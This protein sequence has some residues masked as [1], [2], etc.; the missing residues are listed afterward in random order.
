ME[1]DAQALPDPAQCSHIA[2]KGQ[3]QPSDAERLGSDCGNCRRAVHV[4]A[5][6][7]ACGRVLGVSSRPSAGHERFGFAVRQTSHSERRDLLSNFSVPCTF[8]RQRYSYLFPSCASQVTVEE[9]E[10]F[11]S[12]KRLQFHDKRLT[13]CQSL[14]TALLP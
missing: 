13:F 8:S 6:V 5:A 4:I 7:L 12:P 10:G 3:R 14:V 11:D 1:C 2:V 9:K